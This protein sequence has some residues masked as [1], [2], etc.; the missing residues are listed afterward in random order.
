[1][2]SISSARASTFLMVD[3][4]ELVRLGVR[5]LLNSQA[6][7]SGSAVNV[8]EAGSLCEALALYERHKDAIDLV[9]LDLALPDTRGLNGLTTFRERHPDARIV[10]ISGIGTSGLAQDWLAQAVL[11]AGA[12]AFLPKTA[13]LREVVSLVRACGLSGGAVGHLPL[14][15]NEPPHADRS[16]PE[17]ASETLSPRH[18]SVFQ[19]ILEG[20]NN[21][22][23]AE[24]LHLSEGT[25]KNYVSTI[26]LRLEVRSRAQLISSLR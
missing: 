11:A 19:L 22:E 10:V 26:L 6:S 1:M 16:L 7:P 18:L 17:R 24:A 20:K 9:L 12:D 4:H 23:I 15:S 3:D 21:R 13:S 8:L 2:T 14:T 5:A 25:V